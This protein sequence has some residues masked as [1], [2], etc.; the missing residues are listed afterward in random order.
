MNGPNFTFPLLMF[1][2]ALPERLMAGMGKLYVGRPVPTKS[3]RELLE[4]I[5]PNQRQYLR[6]DNGDLPEGWSPS[7]ESEAVLA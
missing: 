5:R 6:E 7:L 1:A 3:R 4:T 2:S